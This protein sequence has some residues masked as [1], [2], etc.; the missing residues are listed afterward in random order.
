VFRLVGEAID[1]CKPEIHVP[2]IDDNELVLKV[3]ITAPRDEPFTKDSRKFQS[4]FL[5]E[6]T[7][8]ISFF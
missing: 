5:R 6:L 7:F 8:V 2:I 3:A 1:V 4:H